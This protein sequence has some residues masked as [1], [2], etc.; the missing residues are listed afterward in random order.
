MPQELTFKRMESQEDFP[1]FASLVY[2]EP[3]MR[4]NMGRVFTQEE[5]E[6]YFSYILS[7]TAAHE[8]SGCYRIF[9]QERFLGICFLWIRE[10]GAEIEYMLLPEY[11][12]QGYATKVAH[13]L[14]QL[15]RQH[16]DVSAV[17]GLVDP[18]NIPSQR[19]L[20]K[21]GF[22]FER[23]MPVEEDGSTV[24]IYQIQL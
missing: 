24:D 17:R 22:T 5:A 15:A 8:N 19:V 21:N 9:L 14:C 4:M 7:Y 6:G 13:C 16:S 2:N 12:N 11:W 20:L 23:S 3:V 10:D 18:A 1:A